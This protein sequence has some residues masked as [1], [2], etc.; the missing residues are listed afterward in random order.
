MLIKNDIENN[1][2]SYT[3]DKA[4]NLLTKIFSVFGLAK[5]INSLI[6]NLGLIPIGSAYLLY[7]FHS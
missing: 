6:E 2:N 7:D 3:V 1:F 5:S 4:K